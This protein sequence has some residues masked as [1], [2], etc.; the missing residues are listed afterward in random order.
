MAST[1][2]EIMAKSRELYGAGDIEGAKRL[3]R[4][5]LERK[6]GGLPP[7]MAA[8]KAAREGALTV[9]PESA[10]RHAQA[11]ESGMAP[12]I[13]A[14]KTSRM[15][16]IG[17]GALQGLTFG[18][19]DE[20]VSAIRPLVHDG[21]T[22][23]GQLASERALL[24]KARNDRP[25]YAY[26]GEIAGAVAAPIG[27]AAK[28]GSLAARA[29]RSALAGGI[30]G[31]LYGF[32]SGEGGAG[33][34]GKGAVISALLGAG[35]GGALPFVGK[36]LRMAYDKTISAPLSAVS[37]RASPER[38]GGYI[39][40]LVER[41]GQSTDDIQKAIS[42]AAAEGQPEF[43]LADALGN[44]GQRALA[45]V[46]RTPGDARTVIADTL[47]Q[48][49]NNQ[50][51]RIASFLADAFDGADTAKARRL[52]AETARRAEAKVN[53][54]VADDLAGPVNLNGAIDKIDELLGRDPIL[55]NGSSLVGSEFGK[56]LSAL[57][58]KLQNGGEQLIDF[59][60]VADLKS[61][62]YTMIKTNPKLQAQFSSVYDEL[63]KALE[64]ASAGYRKANDSYR[65]A[66]K[67][68][69]AF[70]TGQSASRGSARPDDTVGAFAALTGPEKSAFKSGYVD[71]LIARV[72]AAAPGVNKARPL[73]ADKYAQEFSAMDRTGL[74]AP[75]LGREGKMFETAN[76]A[77]GG[78]KTAD[79]LADI[80]D[81]GFDSGLI[82]NFLMGNLKTAAVQAGKKAIDAA[83]GHNDG[84]RRLVA[85]AL[86][87][88][89][90]TKAIG[91]YLAKS[92]KSDA[93]SAII[94]AL[95]AKMIRPAYPGIAA[96]ASK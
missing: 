36:G 2:E 68:L 56:R 38:A 1:Y 62:L 82:A 9:S 78:S 44:P 51:N 84:T 59:K 7:N 81:T 69:D 21:E 26:G 32:G 70:D 31:G 22:Y 24:E 13:E 43:V 58:A 15:D 39:A 41:S 42:R 72:E 40:K 85:E 75:R 64:A 12:I 46:A 16:A 61:D 57:R 33:E 71:P 37:G 49:Q 14:G 50:G 83:S 23:E 4:I 93:R 30:G 73:L 3:A 55:E 17:R 54:G 77:L 88:G 89:D 95:L 5:A 86:L 74:L 29:G 94:E 34:R 66:S 28:G 18:F 67:V 8:A 60:R 52:A 27:A 35:V 96:G 6:G 10:A 53:Y 91:P 79:N 92:V 19:G 76:A 25:G 11:T 47:T 20:I 87:G 90:I 65:A 48:R 45:G 63:D 80:A